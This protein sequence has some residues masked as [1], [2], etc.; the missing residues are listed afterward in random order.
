MSPLRFTW[1]RRDEERIKIG[2]PPDGLWNASCP[3]NPDCVLSGWA[4][5]DRAR[6]EEL[7]LANCEDCNK[8]KP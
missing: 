7:H 8:D 1:T 4:E 2:L 3:K 6:A 5:E